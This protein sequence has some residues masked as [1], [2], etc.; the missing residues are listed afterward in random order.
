VL[1]ASCTNVDALTQSVV[2]GDAPA[3]VSWSGAQD[4][5]G[6][7]PHPVH[8]AWLDDGSVVMVGKSAANGAETA[9]FITRWRPPDGP[10]RGR[11]VDGGSD[12]VAAA[13]VL[14]ADT[15]LLQVAAVGDV[16]VAVGFTAAS[17]R[18]DS[19]ALALVLNPET[20][21]VRGELVV[22][23][24][25][26][27]SAAFESI[28]VTGDQIVIGGTTG[29]DRAELEGFKSYG[30]V[31]GGRGLMVE[32]TLTEW[33]A[34][35][36]AAVT[37]ADIGGR[38]TSV[39]EVHSL[40]SLRRWADGRVVAVASDP[41]EVSGLVWIDPEQSARSWLPLDP[42]VE[43]TDLTVFSRPG[44][45]DAVA[46]SGHGGRS[47]IDGRLL[48]VEPSGEVLWETVFGNPG[49][50]PSEAPSEGLAPDAIIYDECWGV[51][52]AEDLLVVACGTGIEGCDVA[53]NPTDRRLCRRDPRRTWRSY[54]V[55][56]DGAGEVAWSR[57]DAFVDPDGTGLASAAEFIVAND[58][59]LLA[60]IDQEFGVGLARYGD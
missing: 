38:V 24:A 13:R 34:A 22:S 26:G 51:Q 55:G 27:R 49:T 31:V 44:E 18:A 23:A 1:L 45:P 3:L 39:P 47:G 41:D 28:T 7:D 33:L 56:I 20:L 50:D 53:E 52:Q 30:N 40:K 46:V 6:E 29:L 4:C 60:I 48:L 58:E 10:A 5:C 12:V 25:T 59:G 54:L 35:D 57:A 11:Y 8:G 9:G 21:A 19:Q 37:P 14:E 15:A 42:R 17:A 36:G 2:F 16:I 43:L 32:V